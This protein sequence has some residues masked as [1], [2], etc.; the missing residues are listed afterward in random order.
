MPA[1]GDRDG[2]RSAAIFA[3]LVAAIAPLSQVY[4]GLDWVRPVLGAVLLSAGLA[5]AARRLGL[6]PL[7]AF[8][9]SL[10]GWALFTAVAFLPATVVLG[11]VPTP[12]T[13]AAGRDLWVRGMEL[14]QL[15]PSPT[16]AEAGLLLLTTTGVWAVAHVVDALASTLRA[17]LRA[18]AAA[19]VLWVVPLSVAPPGARTWTFAVPLLAAAAGLLLA[20]GT[21]EVARFGRLA[22]APGDVSPTRRLAA[23]GWVL[24]GAAILAGAVLGRALPGF[25]AEP[26]YE[27]RGT[28]GTT[29]TTNPIVDIRARLVATNTGP[30]LRVRSD[31]PVYVRTTALDVFSEREEWTSSGISGRPVR[32]PLDNPGVP[33]ETTPAQVEVRLE[34]IEEGAILAPAPY[35][36]VA[37]AG[38]ASEGL[39]YDPRSATFTADTGDVLESGDVYTVTAAVPSP[40]PAALDAVPKPVGLTPATDLPANVPLVVAQTARAIVDA[41]GA[42]TM[43]RQALAIQDELRSWTY[44]LTPAAGHGATAMERFLSTREGYCEQFA[45]TMA[46]MLRTLGIPA[47]LAVGYTPG[48]VDGDGVRTVTNANAHAWVEVLFA[49]HG[50]IAFEPTPRT[51]G[52]VL[53]PTPGD[54]SPDLTVAQQDGREA[55]PQAGPGEIPRPSPPPREAVPQP[56][57][58]ED[59]LALQPGASSA[60]AGG[61]GRWVVLGGVAVGGLA[62]GA[63]WLV[64]RS[65]RPRTDL[66]PEQRV[67]AA[68]ARVERLGAGLGCARRASET[69]AEYLARVGR[70]HPSARRLAAPAAAATYAPAITEEDAVA[71]ERAADDLGEQLLAPLPRRRRAA[72][73]LRSAMPRSALQLGALRR[74]RHG[75]GG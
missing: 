46:V 62:L 14:V 6:G 54:V 17:P 27:V 63:A 51:D 68:R 18:I 30:V 43:F 36:P 52:N 5:L 12:A 70:G 58:S 19:V 32:G 22:V 35:L 41:A 21:D 50:W 44:S 15:R 64:A 23:G 11:F 13:L 2:W 53:V 10:V 37:V 1:G 61:V 20:T 31:R 55:L 48:T 60:R 9:V 8:A 7:G 25:G 69:D 66:P 65:R 59:P 72:V 75:L 24:A 34:G 71:A 38:P 16:F 73:L 57:P 39:R 26:W 4:V 67:D 49:E 3:L 45:G 29:I 42:Q 40:D 33:P 47:R 56:L 28:G 74:L